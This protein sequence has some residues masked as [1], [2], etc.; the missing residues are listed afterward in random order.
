V[1]RGRSSP[2]TKHLYLAAEVKL[3]EKNRQCEADREKLIIS[4]VL[5]VKP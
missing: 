3:A 2:K 1:T 4:S 5:K